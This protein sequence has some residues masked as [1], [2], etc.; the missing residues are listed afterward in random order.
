MCI[1]RWFKPAELVTKHGLRGKI[2]EPVSILHNLFVVYFVLLMVYIIIVILV[3]LSYTCSIV[4]RV[5]IHVCVGWHSRP[6]ESRFQRSDQ[7][8]RHS[9][10]GA[11]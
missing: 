1:Y 3:L 6:V 2:K 8:E 9:Y 5:T 10:V 7:A 4:S 11:V